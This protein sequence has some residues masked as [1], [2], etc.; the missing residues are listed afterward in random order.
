M[1]R[2]LKLQIPGALFAAWYNW[3]QGP[4]PG[5][6]PEVEKHWSRVWCCANGGK[7]D[8]LDEP[9]AIYHTV[10]TEAGISPKRQ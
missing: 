6:G 8:V 7:Y 1:L 4:V 9:A 10:K 3:C 5:R 2:K